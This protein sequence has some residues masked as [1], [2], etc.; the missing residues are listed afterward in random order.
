MTRTDDDILEAW[1]AIAERIGK[2]TRLSVTPDAVRRWAA[3]KRNP[4]PTRRWG[5]E[6]PRIV[7]SAAEVDAWV[8]GRWSEAAP[9]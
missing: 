5:G 8:D 1:R 7:A 4:L 6:R 3:L 9:V 2:R